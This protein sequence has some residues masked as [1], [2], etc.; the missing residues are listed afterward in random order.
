MNAIVDTNVLISGIFFESGPPDKIIKALINGNF[1]LVISPEILTEYIETITEL[2]VSYPRI[3]VDNL[4]DKIFRKSHMYMA[5]RLPRAV[6]RDP[7]DDMFLACAVTSKTKIIVS[8]DRDLLS[9][10]GYKGIEILT[11]RRFVEKYIS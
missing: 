7:K 2:R 5:G 3:N 11:P 8:G 1:N 9:V 4:V 10:S 6:C